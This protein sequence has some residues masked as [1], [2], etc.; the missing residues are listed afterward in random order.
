[1]PINFYDVKLREW[2]QID[3]SGVRKITY[4]TKGGKRHALRAKTGDNRKLTK[5]ISKTD[6]DELDVPEGDFSD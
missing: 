4:D 2:V 3:E 5:F 1:M 6:W